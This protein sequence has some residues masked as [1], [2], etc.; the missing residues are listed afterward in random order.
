MRWPLQ[1]LQPFQQTQLQPPF[2]QSVDSLCHPWFTT[3]NLSYRFPIFETSATA[4]CGTTGIFSF[5]QLLVLL[6]LLPEVVSWW[7]FYCNRIRCILIGLFKG[8]II[9]FCHL[10]RDRE[11]G[12]YMQR[13]YYFI[14]SQS[15]KDLHSVLVC[16]SPLVAPVCIQLV[17]GK[18]AS[19]TQQRL[20]PAWPMMRH[21]MFV[22]SGNQTRQWPTQDE[23]MKHI[24]SFA[25]FPSVQS[26]TI[27]IRLP[28]KLRC[29]MASKKNLYT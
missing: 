12:L 23:C 1:P 10:L 2:G 28:S 14:L 8:P 4:L 29:W 6:R 19:P 21:Q 22:P 13:A 15:T 17:Q 11:A 18:A 5:I 16:C 20:T 9:Y 7:S 25:D 26:P 24:L 27:A 3:I